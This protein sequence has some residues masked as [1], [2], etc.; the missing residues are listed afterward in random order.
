MTDHT[1]LACG[2]HHPGARDVTIHTGEIVSSYS[3]AW[4][5]ETEA[6]T[7]LAMPSS[8]DRRNAVTKVEKYRGK[9]AGDALR[10]S[11]LSMWKKRQADL[12]QDRNELDTIRV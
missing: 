7:I 5:H 4:R 3:E 2:S 8:L 1:C 9:P 11:V 12:A 6:L 10:K